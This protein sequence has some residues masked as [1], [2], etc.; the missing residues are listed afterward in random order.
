MTTWQ[1]DYPS[2]Q[3]WPPGFGG[4]IADWPHT[5]AQLSE[6]HIRIEKFVDDDDLIIRAELPGI[7]PERDVSITVADHT[8]LLSAERRRPEGT[9]VDPHGGFYYGRLSRVIG[10]PPGTVDRY[11]TTYQDGVLVIRLPIAKST[12]QADPGLHVR[13]V[14]AA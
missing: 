10:L 4:G 12:T 11:T 1:N 2:E 5:G 6:R 3:D 13:L 8:M 7:D 9:C 14:D